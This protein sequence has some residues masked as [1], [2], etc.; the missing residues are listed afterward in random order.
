[1]K[2]EFCA[3]QDYLKL[4][5]ITNFESKAL[6][7]GSNRN[8]DACKKLQELSARK[9]S[10]ESKQLLPKFCVNDNNLKMV[11]QKKVSE[12]HQNHHPPPMFPPE[13]R[14]SKSP[15]INMK[16]EN[17]LQEVPSKISSTAQKLAGNFFFRQSISEGEKS[18][19][20]AKM[21]PQFEKRN[22]VGVMKIYKNLEPNHVKVSDGLYKPTQHIST[23]LTRKSTFPQKENSKDDMEEEKIEF[24]NVVVNN[25]KDSSN[26]FR[27]INNCPQYMAKLQ[28]DK[29]WVEKHK[30]K[31]VMQRVQKKIDNR[32]N[33]D[34][35]EAL[36]EM[37]EGK[38]FVFIEIENTVCKVTDEPIEG[39]ADPIVITQVKGTKGHKNKTK[40][41]LYIY[42]RRFGLEF[43][44]FLCINHEVILYTHLEKDI[45]EILVNTFH[46]LKEGIDFAFVICGKPFSK[47]I[48]NNIGPIKSL[49]KIIPTMDSLDK[50]EESYREFIRNKFLI[51]DCDV[52]SYYEHFEE[53]HVPILPIVIQDDVSLSCLNMPKIST[54]PTCNKIKR[55]HLQRRQSSL[56]DLRNVG[57]SLRLEESIKNH[58][59]FY[60]KQLLSQ[61]LGLEQDK[62]ELL[63]SVSISC[64]V[65]H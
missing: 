54:S 25:L 31:K 34:F 42:I 45:T 18:Q 28:K 27:F 60:L 26:Y 43:L 11:G 29:H 49:N 16:E 48:T 46:N 32:I 30:N 44:E 7:V 57:Q 23:N 6:L 9:F 38:R 52:L 64:L 40:K 50:D 15:R 13:V 39:C 51:L 21:T 12:T 63:R 8:I 10:Q 55:K 58:C 62:A 41:K 3:S 22:V 53:I 19:S 2:I 5:L 33:I 47:T 61:S 24:K 35:A 65:N 17:K 59:L 36:L 56:K 37:E 1:M 20:S 14:N 4:N